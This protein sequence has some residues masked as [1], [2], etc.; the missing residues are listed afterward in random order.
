MILADGEIGLYYVRKRDL[1]DTLERAVRLVIS[2]ALAAARALEAEAPGDIEFDFNSAKI[3]FLDRIHYRNEP[4][5]FETVRG[6]LTK[7]L[8]EVFGA[9]V[10]ISRQYDDP[11]A[12]FALRCAIEAA[13][14]D[15]DALIAQ[16]DE[17]LQSV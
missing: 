15:I 12:I 2:S 5:I 17:S 14:L 6:S 7:T 8:S 16:L 13:N 1:P 10:A 3:S 11:R 9:E 4:D